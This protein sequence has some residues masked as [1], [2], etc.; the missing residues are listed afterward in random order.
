ML[1]ATTAMAAS[2][3]TVH[4]ARTFHGISAAPARVTALQSTGVVSG[5]RPI[6]ADT[7]DTRKETPTT[8]MATRVISA[9]FRA[10]WSAQKQSARVRTYAAF[11]GYSSQRASGAKIASPTAKTAVAPRAIQSPEATRERSS[12]SGVARGG[13]SDAV[14]A[15]G[16]HRR[17]IVG[18]ASSDTGREGTARTARQKAQVACDPELSAPGTYSVFSS[19]ATY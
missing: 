5:S 1:V 13:A 14:D 12:A 3:T 6:V 15:A 17:S 10:R 2:A 16:P 18:A 11:S 8:M 19:S 4:C 9:V 7:A